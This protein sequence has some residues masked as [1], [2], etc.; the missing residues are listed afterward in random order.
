M[1]SSTRDAGEDDNIL[2]EQKPRKQAFAL[3]T[4]I[5]AG[6]LLKLPHCLEQGFFHRI[7]PHPVAGPFGQI[8]LSPASG[9][10]F[11]LVLSRKGRGDASPSLYGSINSPQVGGSQREGDTKIK[12]QNEKCK[13]SIQDSNLNSAV[14][15]S[16]I[17][18][19][20]LQFYILLF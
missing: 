2:A 14:R 8:T 10:I 20:A 17:L 3:P 11:N 13:V 15:N 1:L 18:N 19:F 7:L 4:T 16:P 5:S 12:I 6:V 9:G